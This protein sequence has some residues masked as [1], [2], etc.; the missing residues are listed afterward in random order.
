MDNKKQEKDIS[1]AFFETDKYLNDYKILAQ[2]LKNISENIY[3]LE[4]FFLNKEK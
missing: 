2:K 1:S 4:K 3:L